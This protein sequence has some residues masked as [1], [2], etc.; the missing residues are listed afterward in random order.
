[1]YRFKLF[2]CV[3]LCF[4]VIKTSEIEVNCQDL[5]LGQFMCPDP[6]KIEI[7]PKTQQLKGC[8]KENK[9]KGMWNIG[10]KLILL[11]S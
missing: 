3:F 11:I 2:I 4:C 10:K 7:D 1:M 5:R 6:K 9:A 8:S